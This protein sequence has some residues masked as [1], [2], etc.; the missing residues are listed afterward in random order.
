MQFR[1][2]FI[3]DYCKFNIQDVFDYFEWYDSDCEYFAKQL[4]GYVSPKYFCY[5]FKQ[6]FKNNKDD[7]KLPVWKIYIIPKIE[8]Y[9]H[10]ADLTVSYKEN[11]NYIREHGVAEF[12]YSIHKRYNL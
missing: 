12:I 5:K 10:H 9:K 3:D 2:I 4:H 11:S 6:D 7:F 8:K 1:Y